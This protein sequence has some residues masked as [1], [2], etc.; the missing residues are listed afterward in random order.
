MLDTNVFSTLIRGSDQ[1]L[2]DRYLKARNANDD[3][4]L[5]TTVLAELL[6]GTQKKGS[7]RLR[8]AIDQ[9]VQDH[10]LQD[11]DAASAEAYADIRATLEQRGEPIGP[12]DYMIAAVARAHGLTLV[13]HNTREFS[14]VPGLSID[15]W[16]A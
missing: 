9:I 10:P 16:Q 1:R 14:R 4:V 8:V 7:S 13:T 2:I 15:D 12:N 6:F 5:S 3:L 11:F